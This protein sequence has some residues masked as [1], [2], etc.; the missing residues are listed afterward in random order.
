MALP[1]PDLDDRRFQDLVDE[2]KRLVQQRCPEWTDHNVADPGVTL[3]ETFAFMTDQLLWRLNRVPDRNYLKFLELIG[4]RLFAPVAARSPVTFWLSAPRPD[5]VRV[6]AG[7][8]VATLRTETEEAVVFGVD[9]D[10]DIVP[11][12]LALL[13]S[14]PAGQPFRDHIGVLLGGPGEPCF[15]HPPVPGDHLYVGLTDPVP[16]CAVALRF[17]CRI[18]GVGV[19]PLNPP[20]RWEAFDGAGWAPCEVDRDETGGLNRPGDVVLH[21]PASHVA[22]VIDGERAGWLRAVV[23]EAVVG[24]PTYSSSPSIHGLAAMTIGGT[25]GVTHAV[26]VRGEIIG[27]SDG[28]AGQRMALREQPVLAGGP[29]VVIEV[30]ED[31]GADRS[32]W[33][34]WQEVENF[35]DSGPGDRHFVL[36]R[37]AGEVLFGPVVRLADGTLTR[38]GATPGQGATVRIRSYRTGGGRR[39]NVAR[40]AI[41]FLRSSI[42]FV[43]RI[44]NR[45]PA[46]GGV[47]GETL[48][49]A[50]VRGPLQLRTRNRA[51]TAEDYEQ[52]AR[53][54]APEVARVRCV[55]AGGT[56]VSPGEG[57]S[58]GSAPP[59]P[60]DGTATAGGVRVLVVPAAQG[61]VTGRLRFEQ[62]VLSDEVL[63]R[64][65]RHL[66]ERRVVGARL[67]VE[68]PYYQ[69]I[70]VV[71]R[72]RARPRARITEVEQ[73]ATAALYRYYHPILGGPDGDGWPFGRPVH[74]G[75]V[76]AVL[77]GVEGVEYVEDARLFGADPLTGVRGESVPRLELG[78]GAL[79]FSYEHLLRVES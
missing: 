27:V 36:D 16:R 11:C 9:E 54:A 26:E 7:T 60:A 42:P 70:T 32:G 41:Q 17:D 10:L 44:E 74:V 20:L 77:Q 33:V 46:A 6:A 29:E 75:E 69:G 4:V 73:A 22:A 71:A 68:P 18:E 39:G 34:E 1:I 62:L 65:T 47:D 3:I 72:V 21:V 55:P 13:R 23:T 15:S 53:E 79:V 66:D 24:Q 64:I 35:A 2:A 30:A 59:V 48:E 56:A 40:G 43:A 12:S 52:L 25:M 76:Y 50:K 49:E 8:E 51:V 58:N 28:V 19:D 14:Q 57:G 38:Y 45:W 63:E 67:V 31:V 78:P 61:D 37:R 5:T